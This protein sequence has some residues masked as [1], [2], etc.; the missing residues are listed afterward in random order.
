MALNNSITGRLGD[1]RYRNNPIPPGES[2][3]G[4]NTPSRYS[5]S[6]MNSF[7]QPAGDARASL[8]RRFTTDLTKMQSVGPIGQQPAQVAEQVETPITVR[9]DHLI[10]Y[11]NFGQLTDFKK[12]LHK[13]RLV[14]CETPPFSFTLGSSI[15]PHHPLLTAP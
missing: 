9:L 7:S 14:S 6:F 15:L 4:N 13:A 12:D 2:Q 1:L 8:Q 5:G 3:S 10:I 11:H